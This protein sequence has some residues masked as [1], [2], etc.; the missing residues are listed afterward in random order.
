TFVRPAL[1]GEHVTTTIRLVSERSVEG[2][3]G[4][5]TA[6]RDYE[7]RYRGS[8]S[9][10]LATAVSTLFF[11]DANEA[12]QREKFADW[13]RWRYT[14]DQLQEIEDASDNEGQRYE[15]SPQVL[16]G[17]DVHVD[18]ALPPIVRGPLTSE[19]MTLFVGATHPSAGLESF[20]RARLSGTVPTFLHPRSGV[21]ETYAA[22]LID[23]VSAREMGYPAA[24]D[25]GIDRISYLASLV[26]SWM[27]PLGTLSRL[28][29]RLDEPHMLGDTSWCHGRVSE[30]TSEGLTATATVQLEVRNQ[31]GT[32]TARGDAGVTLP[33]RGATPTT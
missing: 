13:K 11:V 28:S 14:P 30:V 27:G 31:A 12:R 5:T 8:T 1:I 4:G 18:D 10:D 16:Y 17:D 19:E 24:H 21:F 9:G 26:T 32:V 25:A 20:T 23:D 15:Q 22:G 29:V 7:I 6:V 3:F 33:T 2:R